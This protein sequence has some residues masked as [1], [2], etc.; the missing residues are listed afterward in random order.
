[1]SQQY[2]IF[3]FLKLNTVLK[4]LFAAIPINKNLEKVR[5]GEKKKYFLVQCSW[6]KSSIWQ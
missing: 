3:K 4:V 6:K 1:M 5:I 2:I